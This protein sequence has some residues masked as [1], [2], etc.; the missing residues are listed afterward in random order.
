M[1]NKVIFLLT[2]KHSKLNEFVNL[3]T[4][5]IV[6][7]LDEVVLQAELAVVRHCGIVTD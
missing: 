2:V 7:V 3:L 6:P 5:V 4:H 1:G